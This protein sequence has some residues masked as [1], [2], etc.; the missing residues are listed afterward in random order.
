MM[1]T[2]K[3]VTT[4]DQVEEFEVD[5]S[6]IWRYPPSPRVPVPPLY[7]RRNTG[8]LSDLTRRNWT[9]Q[10]RSRSTYMGSSRSTYICMLSKLKYSAKSKPY[11]RSRLR[12]SLCLFTR[13]LV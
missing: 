8:D 10:R 4:A 9:R 6:A 7:G 1:L 3:T 2:M 12:K 11:N 5:I 13:R